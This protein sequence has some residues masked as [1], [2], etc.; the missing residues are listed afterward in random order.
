MSLGVKFAF[1]QEVT[2]EMVLALPEDVI[3]REVEHGFRQ[4]ARRHPE[5][6]VVFDHT[7]VLSV[8]RHFMRQ[9]YLVQVL[10]DVIRAQLAIEAPREAA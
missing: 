5:I 10:A 8:H 7:I 6:V 4:M 9:S 1:V 3:L 2:E